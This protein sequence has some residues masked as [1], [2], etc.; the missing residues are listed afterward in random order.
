M[1]TTFL[2]LLPLQTADLVLGAWLRARLVNLSLPVSEREDNREAVGYICQDNSGGERAPDA[3]N[4]YLGMLTEQLEK[5]RKGS[6]FAGKPARLATVGD[7]CRALWIVK[8]EE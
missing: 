7:S 6:I 1:K 4:P 8:H 5:N 3:Y 2:L